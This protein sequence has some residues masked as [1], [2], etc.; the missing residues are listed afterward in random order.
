MELEG[1][2]SILRKA[3]Y[4]KHL[5][6]GA[7]GLAYDFS[8]FVRLPLYEVGLLVCGKPLSQRF[9]PGDL[10]FVALRRLLRR[11]ICHQLSH[12]SGEVALRKY[13]FG[14]AGLGL[15]WRWCAG[16]G[17]PFSV[18]TTYYIII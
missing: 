7:G 17:F 11:L 16:R 4:L 13:G 18:H 15:G 2:A 14:C 9:A 6:T 3:F 8:R 1:S 5:P 10:A 12:G